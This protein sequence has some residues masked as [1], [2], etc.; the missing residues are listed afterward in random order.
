MRFEALLAKLSLKARLM[1]A[2]AA[3]A[4]LSVTFT[5]ILAIDYHRIA[6][7]GAEIAKRSHDEMSRALE[8]QDSLSQ[9]ARLASLGEFSD[10][11]VTHF[12]RLISQVK[13]L[14]QSTEVSSAADQVEIQF[15]KF[16][17]TLKSK[18]GQN[19][20]LARRA[21]YEEAA[22]AV[23]SLTERNQNSIY[24][25]ADTLQQ[26]QAY[27]FQ[28]GLISVLIFL[29]VLGV[30]TYKLISLI[31]A[32]FMQMARFIDSID[33]ESDSTCGAIEV[34]SFGSTPEVNQ[35]AGS[36]VKLLE[37]LGVYRALN[38]RR[39]LSEKRRA[40]IIAASIT[41]GIILL[42]GQEVL[43]A[44]PV[45]ERI[46]KTEEKKSSGLLGSRGMRAV[47]AAVQQTMP[48]E[49]SLETE[50]GKHHF[51]IQALPISHALI[52]RMGDLQTT[53]VAGE[54]EATTIVVAQDVTIVK[55]SQEAKGHFLATLSHEVKTPVT[56]LTLATRMLLRSVDK[57]PDAT[58]QILVKTC[59]EDVDRLRVLLDDLLTV[60][61]FDS[62]TQK[63]QFQNADL[64]KLVK[65][66]VQSF[67]NSALDKHVELKYEVLNESRLPLWI[68]MDPSKVAWAISSLLTNALRHAPKSSTVEVKLEVQPGMIEVRIKDSGPGIDKR[69]L[70]RIFDK[71]SSFYDIRVARSGSA[72]L[73]LSIAREIVQ[74]HG[75]KIWATSEVG[76]GA[77][78]GFNLPLKQLS[79]LVNDEVVNGVSSKGA[80]SGASS[81]SG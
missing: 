67:K 21:S 81:R 62:L 80:I 38:L 27:T 32:P 12:K 45:A 14:S 79:S 24:A 78:F 28:V 56:S 25:L 73:G 76:E 33:V 10:V 41:D 64:G 68:S 17:N 30:L 54:F 20:N 8:M 29:L 13:T 15:N 3:I 70:E 37:R 74:A 59:T 69:R 65:H 46:L 35:V 58:Q 9:I 5:S 55:E 1:I 18:A 48:V 40:D 66:Q 71:F 22:A 75:G 57:M 23:G 77:E 43:Y 6:I 2:S 42:K 63:T 44:N 60:S 53:R 52:D 4:L 47:L 34:P 11:E 50:D 31:T 36:F 61:R 7:G 49:F 19:W 26:K 51:L 39:L 72:G 16:I